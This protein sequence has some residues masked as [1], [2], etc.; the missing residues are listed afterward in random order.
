[1]VSPDHSPPPRPV[2]ARGAR[3]ALGSGTPFFPTECTQA[4]AYWNSLLFS[5]LRVRKTG[6]NVSP[7]C[8]PLRLVYSENLSVVR[9]LAL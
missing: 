2:P 7:Q 4:L 3:G 9:I 1:M 6:P 5:V 8:L